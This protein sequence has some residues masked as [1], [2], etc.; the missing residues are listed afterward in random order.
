M[1]FGD[2]ANIQLPI[3]SALPHTHK[4]KVP[5]NL[6]QWGFSKLVEDMWSGC[7]GELS[8]VGGRMQGGYDQDALDTCMKLSKN[9]SNSNAINCNSYFFKDLLNSMKKCPALPV[10]VLVRTGGIGNF[11]SLANM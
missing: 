3:F 6:T 7:A 11:K 9:K 8:G 4:H 5:T 10:S 1:Y 2:V